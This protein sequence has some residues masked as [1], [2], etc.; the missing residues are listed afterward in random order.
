MS[1]QRAQVRLKNATRKE[2]RSV[3]MSDSPSPDQPAGL[4]LSYAPPVRARKRKFLVIPFGLLT[5]AAALAGVFLLAHLQRTNVM[6]WHYLY[7]IPYGALIVGAVAGSGYVISG[8]FVDLR[9]RWGIFWLIVLLQ[10]LAFFSTSYVE[11]LTLGPFVD[12]MT[13]ARVRFFR[14]FHVMTTS[15]KWVG[16]RETLGLAGYW[17]R[18]LE[19]AG[20]VLGGVVCLVF[21]TGSDYCHLCSRYRKHKLLT[22]IPASAPYPAELNDEVRAEFEAQSLLQM[23]QAEERLA[24]LDQLAAD[25]DAAAY[26]AKTPRKCRRAFEWNWRFARVATTACWCRTCRWGKRF[27]GRRWRCHRSI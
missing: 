22:L 10:T 24:Q 4:L 7:V 23:E 17:F 6:G 26:R 1:R 2:G 13:G 15:L 21:L 14:Y 27:R 18:A 5:T 25:G 8:W 20:F 12:R 3:E 19:L 9:V 16:E 11:F